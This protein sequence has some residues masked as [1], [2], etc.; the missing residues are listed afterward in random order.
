M[1]ELV[2]LNKYNRLDQQENTRRSWSY[3]TTIA[4]CKLAI[5]Q[6]YS[7]AQCGSAT[8]QGCVFAYHN[9]RDHLFV[10]HSPPAGYI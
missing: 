7:D 3:I 6:R 5:Y 8:I 2:M 1:N 4:S 9:H 10:L